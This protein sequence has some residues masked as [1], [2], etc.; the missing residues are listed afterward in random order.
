METS[1]GFPLDPSD[2]GNYHRFVVFNFRTDFVNHYLEISEK[3]ILKDE[4]GRIV[5]PNQII[6]VQVLM[7]EE[8]LSEVQLTNLTN[9]LYFSYKNIKAH[10]G[11]IESLLLFDKQYLGLEWEPKRMQLF[12]NQHTYMVSTLGCFIFGVR[13]YKHFLFENPIFEEIRRSLEIKR[14]ILNRISKKNEDLSADEGSIS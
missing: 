9:R 4:R 11:E 13:L 1:I 14:G 10:K 5:I 2:I 3:T 8:Q 6:T 12:V 7:T